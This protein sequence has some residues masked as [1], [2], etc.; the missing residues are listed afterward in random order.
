MKFIRTVKIKTISIVMK[1]HRLQIEI[2]TWILKNVNTNFKKY[3]IQIQNIKYC[4][5]WHATKF[6]TKYF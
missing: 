5:V 4:N 3:T 1:N 6:G 2:I